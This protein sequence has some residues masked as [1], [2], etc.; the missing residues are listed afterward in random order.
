MKQIFK[1]SSL[2]V[3]IALLFAGCTKSNLATQKET[4]VLA[5]T[6]PTRQIIVNQGR[7]KFA[8]TK[9]IRDLKMK[10][11]QGQ[12]E[13]V[14]KEIR[15]I[16]ILRELENNPSSQGLR[17][18]STCNCTTD[19]DFENAMVDQ[20]YMFDVGNWTVK[21]DYCNERTFALYRPAFTAS[22]VASKISN[23]AQCN[24][25]MYLG[26]YTFSFDYDLL[27]EI[28]FLEDSINGSAA[29][30][31][32]RDVAASSRVGW[33]YPHLIN[34]V[35]VTTW[36]N[37]QPFQAIV[38]A[39]MVEYV[40]GWTSGR[41]KSYM[42]YTSGVP[43]GFGSYNFLFASTTFRERCGSTHTS[44]SGTINGTG[45][46]VAS[47]PGH[48]NTVKVQQTYTGARIAAG[49]GSIKVRARINDPNNPN[50]QHSADAVILF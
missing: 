26:L 7:L 12:D 41:I 9:T 49:V 3:A 22:E 32:C 13:K 43:N 44:F 40:R 45:I 10:L 16:D 34:N 29:G 48:D 35:T 1:N 2:I 50:V 23:L 11:G 6:E 17:A 4:P 33:V 24:F 37:G 19:L 36:N 18:S 38:P 15:N 8:S 14:L 47:H 21:V 46:E 20:F 30:R 28:D 27:D 42:N 25:Q 5:V 31:R 39:V